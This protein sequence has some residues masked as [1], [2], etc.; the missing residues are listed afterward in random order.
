MG[1][2][3]CKHIQQIHSDIPPKKFLE[4]LSL[5]SQLEFPEKERGLPKL[6]WSQNVTGR[7]NTKY[8]YSVSLF[9][10]KFRLRVSKNFLGEISFCFC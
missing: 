10:W 6:L 4:T 9:P 5:F 7:V 1:L 3:S 8:Y 2:Y